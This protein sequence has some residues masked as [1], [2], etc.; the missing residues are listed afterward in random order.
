[1]KK[2]R[3]LLILLACSPLLFGCSD[4]GETVPEGDGGSGPVE[5]SFADPFDLAFCPSSYPEWDCVVYVDGDVAASGDGFSWGSAVKTVQEGIDLAY[6]GVGNSAACAQWQV[7]VKSGTYYVHQTCSWN[8]VRLRAGVAVY[9]GFVGS[10]TAVHEREWEANETILDGRDGPDGVQHVYSVVFGSDAAVIDGFTIQQGR[11]AEEVQLPY[12]VGAG[13]LNLS[14][15]PTVENCTFRD[16]YSASNG[17]GMA[18]V[19][20]SSPTVIGCSFENNEA[21]QDGGGMANDEDSSPEVDRC[22]FESNEAGLNGGGIVT[23]AGAAHVTNSVFRANRAEWDGG[24]LAHLG[25]VAGTIEDCIFEANVAAHAGGGAAL[26]ETEASVVRSTFERNEAYAGGGIVV[27]RSTATISDATFQQNRAVQ[28]DYDEWS[29][30]G[31]IRVV[32]DSSV[33]IENTMVV[34][35]EAHRT[36]GGMNVD[37]NSEVT[38]SNCQFAGNAGGESGGG[39]SVS[40]S[41]LTLVDTEISDN[42]ATTRVGGGLFLWEATADVERCRFERNQA[43]ENGGGVLVSPATAAFTAVDSLFLDNQAEVG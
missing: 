4:G 20:G 14:A 28:S 24:G 23:A 22:T 36:G 25:D 39:I 6:C 11:V 42:E 16:N 5:C 38:V 43:V 2:L 7:W 34:R 30:G 15:S 41:T 35:N 29:Q 26:G 13:M 3:S 9:G 1:M 21:G 8:M 27:W 32:A 10:E 40:S 12:G 18:N 33:V 19:D 37:K 31:G 17:G